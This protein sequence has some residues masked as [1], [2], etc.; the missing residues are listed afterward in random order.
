MML[1]LPVLV[2]CGSSDTSVPV[3][4]PPTASPSGAPAPPVPAVAAPT[5]PEGAPVVATGDYAVAIAAMRAKH[6]ALTAAVEAGGPVEQDVAALIALSADVLK[7]SKT[8]PQADRAGAN[9]KG[10]QVRQLAT[11]VRTRAAAG[12]AAGAREALGRMSA[13]IDA[14]AALQK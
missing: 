11:T 4:P 8:L 10:F 1:L 2:A 5:P 9:M 6:A 3:L 7:S 14:L 13:T 12:D